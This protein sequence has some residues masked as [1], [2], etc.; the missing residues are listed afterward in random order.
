MERGV[1]KG[2]EGVAR[3]DMIWCNVMWR[4]V[5]WCCVVLFCVMHT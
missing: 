4:D 3:S 1:G 2:E 5:A